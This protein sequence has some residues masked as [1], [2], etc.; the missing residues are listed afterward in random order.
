MKIEEL[1]TRTICELN[2]RISSGDS[3]ELIQASGLLRKL[4]LDKEPWIY[5]VIKESGYPNK[6]IFGVAEFDNPPQII[7]EAEFYSWPLLSE[8]YPIKKVNLEMFLKQTVFLIKGRAFSVR[9]LIKYLAHAEGGI[10]IDIEGTKRDLGLSDEELDQIRLLQEQLSIKG[11][12][13]ISAQ[14]GRVGE[15]V[16]RAISPLNTFLRNNR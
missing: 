15:I 16:V 3:Y 4:L 11:A 2:E 12:E 6:I 9:Q 7:Y 1:F 14:V 13:S 10:H 5:Q 8:R